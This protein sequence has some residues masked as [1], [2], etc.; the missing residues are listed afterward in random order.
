MQPTRLRRCVLSVPGSSEKMLGKAADMEIDGV[1]LDLEDAVAP[2]AKADARH[3]IVEALNAGAWTPRSVS[4]RINDVTTPYCHRDIIEVVE[5]AGDKLATIIL[6]KARDAADVRFVHLLL[7]QLEQGLGLT[8]R[9]G[10][11]CLIEDVE[12]LQNVQQIAA[13]SDRL[14]ALVLGMG[15]YSASQGMDVANVGEDDGRYPPDLWHYPRYQM[16]IACRVNG[17]DAVD[18]PIANFRDE[19]ANRTD[20]ERARVLGMDGKWAIHP[21]QVP[22]AVS[23]FTPDAERV[24]LARRHRDAYAAALQQGL[25]AID[26]DGE[27]VDAATIRLLQNVLDRADLIGM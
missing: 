6:T 20:C 21:N 2:D 26:V 10:I 17:L 22:I 14:E 8:N 5:G 13:S 15:D 25:G 16:T 23:T 1:F 27:M 19:A 9:I 24:A 18:G 7:D 11:E 12:G 4:V 3:M